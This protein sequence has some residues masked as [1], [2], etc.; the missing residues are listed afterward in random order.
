MSSQRRQIRSAKSG[1]RVGSPTSLVRAQSAPSEADEAIARGVRARMLGKFAEAAEEFRRATRLRP[2]DPKAWHDLGQCL[3]FTRRPE[4]A[5][6]T[7]DEALRVGPDGST[8]SMI[9]APRAETLRVL[10]RFD[11]AAEGYAAHLRYSP[12][13]AYMHFRRGETLL[14]AGRLRE[15]WRCLRLAW[16]LRWPA[17]PTDHPGYWGGWPIAGERILVI[18]DQGYGDKFMF[19]RF[20]ELVKARGAEVLLAAPAAMMPLLV[21]AGGADR[22][23]ALEELRGSETFVH[24]HCYMAHLP[25]AL[26]ID[27]FG[28]IP[29]RSP[30]LSADAG[31]AEHWR[32]ELARYSGLRVGIAWRGAPANPHDGARSFPLR[33]FA[34]LARIPGVS[35]LSLQLGDGAAELRDP[36]L[37]FEVV[38]LGPALAGDVGAFREASAILENLDLFIGPCS[39]LAHLSGALARPC[40]VPLARD[41]DWR[42]GLD[43]STTPWYPQST[44]FRQERGRRLDRAVRPHRRGGY[45]PGERWS[46]RESGRSLRVSAPQDFA[47]KGRRAEPFQ[48]RADR[49]V[50]AARLDQVAADDRL[51]G[52]VAALNQDIG[53]NCL[54]Q[55]HRRFIV[56]DH[57]K[58]DE[59]VQR[60]HE[61]PLIFRDER[62]LGALQSGDGG[63][64]IQTEDEAVSERAG[65]LEQTG[66]AGMED[67]EATVC[68]DDLAARETDLVGH[69]PGAIEDDNL[70]LGAEQDHRRLTGR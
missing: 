48:P 67:V 29:T 50:P 22:L 1:H 14:A 54:D 8:T 68:E 4:E 44:L 59:G 58:V 27:T 32:G 61:R 47:G 43:P 9:H 64:G 38:D 6:A 24:A 31:R 12:D 17:D 5:L 66:M 26:G 36:D 28:D 69:L 35:L 15:G 13:D 60:E 56:E 11:E 23:V 45:G 25:E 57:D 55:R 34:P 39:S 52:I 42:W 53:A 51:G 10:G 40:F 7:F 18:A 63:V 21:T 37:G 49:D 33:S 46:L 19:V 62:T 41:A 65:V 20:M 70:R 30:Y 3:H 2:G 16:P